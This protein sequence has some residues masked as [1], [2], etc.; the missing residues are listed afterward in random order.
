MR[1]VEFARTHGV[2]AA[3]PLGFTWEPGTWVTEEDP[4]M[5]QAI[6]SAV[7]HDTSEAKVTVAGVPDRP[8]HRRHA[9]PRAWP[10]ADVN[11]DMIVQNVSEHGHHRH[12]LHRAPTTTSTTAIERLRRRSRPRSAPASVTDR[13]RH[14][15]GSASSA[16]A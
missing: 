6:I 11:V 9:V 12:L 4:D 3:R 16:P 2:D 1:S 10:T 7:I 14:R 15:A 13:R 8:G 5:E